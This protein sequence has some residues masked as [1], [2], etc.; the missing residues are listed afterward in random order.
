L[1]IAVVT[2]FVRHVRGYVL[3]PFLGCV[4]TH[5]PN[6]IFIL[7]VEWISD[8]GF[9]VVGSTP[10]DRPGRCGLSRPPRDTRFDRRPWARLKASSLI[11]TYAKELYLAPDLGFDN[12]VGKEATWGLIGT[13]DLS[14]RKHEWLPRICHRIEGLGP[15]QSLLLLAVPTSI[16]EPLKLVA[17]AIAGDG[18]WVTGMLVIIA[19]YAASLLLVERLFVIV[20]PKLMTL[21]WFARFWT[22]LV[23]LRVRWLK[24]VKEAITRWISSVWHAWF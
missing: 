20:K 12:L 3:R 19:A 7:A 11:A 1:E 5:Y 14:L 13:A 23:G 10:P 8:N 22:W 21:S 16:V 18:H 15:Y 4:E 24:A 17:V 9:E 6:R 2:Q